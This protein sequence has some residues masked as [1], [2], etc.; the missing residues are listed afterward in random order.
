MKCILER[1]LPIVGHVT[2]LASGGRVVCR[3]P[4]L[5][6]SVRGSPGVKLTLDVSFYHGHK[7]LPIVTLKRAG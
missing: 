5:G 4:D 3:A 7:H 6:H 1:F 2:K